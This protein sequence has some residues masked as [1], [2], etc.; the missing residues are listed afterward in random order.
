MSLNL[1]PDMLLLLLRRRSQL[2]RGD[3]DVRERGLLGSSFSF[4]LLSLRLLSQVFASTRLYAAAEFRSFTLASNLVVVGSP[5]LVRD[6]RRNRGVR[7]YSGRDSD[8]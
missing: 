1:L 3:L 5:P 4:F 7:D 8:I 2:H 6:I